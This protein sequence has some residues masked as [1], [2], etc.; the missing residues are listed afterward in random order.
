[1]I[2]NT[3][4]PVAWALL[5]Q[6]LDD[7]RQHLDALIA[8]MVNTGQVDEEKFRVDLGHVYAHLN[9]AWHSRNQTSEITDQQ[10]TTFSQ[11]PVDV[12]PVG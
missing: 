10:W 6:E 5:V 12:P 3:S 1:M 8:E 7:G 4:D 11:F 9:R 2:D